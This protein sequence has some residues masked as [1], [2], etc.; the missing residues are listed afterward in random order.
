MSD[1]TS[2]LM[3][4]GYGA[5][6]D[7]GNTGFA[8]PQAG[9]RLGLLF[10]AGFIWGLITAFSLFA[11]GGGVV[12]G[13]ASVVDIV[14]LVIAMVLVRAAGGTFSAGWTHFITGMFIIHCAIG[15]MSAFVFTPN[16]L[17]VIKMLL[18]LPALATVI[19]LTSLGWRPVNAFRA[20][21]TLAGVVFVIYHFCYIDFSQ[22]LYAKYRLFLYLNPN[23]VAYISM[24]TGLSLLNYI[25]SR[26]RERRGTLGILIFTALVGACA[27]VCFSTKSR[28]AALAFA[29]GILVTISL[30]ARKGRALLV[31]LV[32]GLLA[33]VALP[34]VFSDAAD[35]ISDLYELHS[36]ARDI[37]GGTGRFDL[38]GR[39]I[40]QGILPHPIIGIGPGTEFSDEFIEIGNPHNA[41]LLCL[42]ETGI[43]GTIP[44]LVVLGLCGRR[45]VTYFADPRYHFA[46][47]FLAAGLSESL[48]EVMLFSIGNPAGL[49]FL[50]SMAVLTSKQ[51][52]RNEA[53]TLMHSSEF[54]QELAY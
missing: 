51:L 3:Y 34:G 8:A 28:N 16:I 44:V 14:A 31:V 15:T 1:Y 26:V 21:V 27:V 17:Y 23:G 35:N 45:A 29:V 20:G 22:L 10:C 9:Q 41:I 32:I 36:S 47:V 24:M 25:V 7:L 46:I 48:A 30:A 39:I 37:S 12:I 40:T 18:F 52:A 5:G 6:D 2:E 42:L 33:W 11:E 49:L 38:W 19:A 54:P 50:L 13:I 43:L 53:G 4:R